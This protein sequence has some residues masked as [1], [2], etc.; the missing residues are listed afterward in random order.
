M[1]PAFAIDLKDVWLL[2][3]ATGTNLF[4]RGLVSG[5][6]PELW[7]CDRPDDIRSLYQDWVDAGSDIFITNSFG[8]TRHRLK[9]HQAQDRVH[10]I[11]KAAATLA[12][13]VADAAERPVYVAGSIGP[14]G[15]LLEPLGALTFEGAKAAFREQI[16]GLVA[17]GVDLLWI[18]TLSDKQELQAALEAAAEFSIPCVSTLSFDTNGKTM[19][20]INPADLP[21]LAQQAQNPSLLAVGANCGTG[22]AELCATMI[23]MQ[24]KAAQPYALVAKA[25]CGIPAYV[26]G[27]IRYSGTVELMAD[28]AAMAR[29]SGARFIGGCCGTRPEH[30]RVMRHALDT[31]PRSAAPTLED[32]RA[33]LG[34]ISESSNPKPERETRRKRRSQ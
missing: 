11:N 32:V 13:E 4:A 15:E 18:E 1:K 12:R 30:I 28:Y 16:E 33:R 14:T 31:R 26:D 6:A 24:S 10:E 21:E 5:D 2:D 3:G 9:L 22:P 23:R 25:N 20:G 34:D 17:G 7:N 27:E 8:G 19:M 29:D